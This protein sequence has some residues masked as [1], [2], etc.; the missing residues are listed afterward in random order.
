MSKI[1][2]FGMR[3]A[4]ITLALALG[5]QFVLFQGAGAQTG[6]TTGGITVGSGNTITIGFPTGTV[7]S[8][9]GTT[10]G[11][12]IGNLTIC[13]PVTAF[14]SGGTLTQSGVLINLAGATLTGM[15]IVIGGNFCSQIQL[16]VING[17]VTNVFVTAN[18]TGAA[19]MCTTRC[20]LLSPVG[21][22]T[23]TLS[24]VPIAATPTEAPTVIHRVGRGYED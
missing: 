1:R 24:L 21:V 3:S 14:T 15:P 16:N 6:N 22:T 23:G 2:R 11:V 10:T 17:Q 8:P 19:F 20:F 12:V 13:G 7:T 5:L 9:L 18:P 4:G